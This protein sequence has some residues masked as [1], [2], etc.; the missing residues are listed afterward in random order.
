MLVLSGMQFV[1][2]IYLLPSTAQFHLV[3][4]F[5]IQP[6]RTR[7]TISATSVGKPRKTSSSAKYDFIFHN[8]Q[9]QTSILAQADSNEVIVESIDITI[10]GREE[11]QDEHSGSG[12]NDINGSV[13]KTLFLGIEPTPDILAIATIYFVEGALG[14]ARLAQ[15]FLLKDELK[16][17]P[18]ELSATVGLLSLPWTIKPL[19]GFLSDGFPIGGYRRRPYLVLAGMVGFLSY[20]V[21][22]LGLGTDASADGF[23]T[24]KTFTITVISLLLSSAS[25]ALS[26]VVADGIV[27]QKTREAAERGDDPAIAGG[28]QS[29]CWGSAA[30]GALISAYFSGSLVER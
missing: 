14:L 5:L 15:T 18:A 13:L 29:L 21:L 23:D 4:C 22:A 26:D 1:L 16:L 24:N 11:D 20:M 3:N 30:I 8:Q 19:Y 27:V 25:I 17:G 28:L 7:I 6:P 10:N 9:R 12:S 2:T